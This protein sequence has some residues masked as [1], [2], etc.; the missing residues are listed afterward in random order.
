MTAVGKPTDT[1]LPTEVD[2]AE[3]LLLYPLFAAYL[4]GA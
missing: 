4:Q 1:L 2:V 3:I